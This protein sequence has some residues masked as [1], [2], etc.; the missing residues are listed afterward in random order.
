MSTRTIQASSDHAA[1]RGGPCPPGASPETDAANQ[2]LDLIASGLSHDLRAPLRA[3]R[4]FAGLVGKSA[5][6]RLEP[7][8][9]DYLLRIQRASDRMAGLL[10]GLVEWSRAATS[11]CKPARVDVS[12]L[13]EWAVAELQE[14]EPARATNIL[15]APG[16]T[17][18]GDERLLK[19][20]LVHLL[21]NAWRFSRDRDEI[22]IRV[23]GVAI[24]G[25]L[26]VSISDHGHGIDMRYADKLFQ[27]FQ[28]LHGEDQ[29]A[30]HG[31]GLATAQ[32]IAQRHGGRVWAESELGVGSVF[33]VDLP[34]AS[35]AHAS[36][37]DADLPAMG[38]RGSTP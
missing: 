35:E 9:K 25:G 3:I 31:L 34:R 32:R 4:S 7:T 1:D 20:L 29:G 22:F 15:V 18:H 21:R 23:E 14:E 6:E 8:E 38:H 16:L 13:A 27:P 24:D 5:G 11:E 37:S 2:Q 12:L 10:D 36:A 17:T 26:R 19:L 30:G 33:H 28:R